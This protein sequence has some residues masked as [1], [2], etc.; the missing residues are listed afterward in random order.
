MSAL[1]GTPSF[2]CFCVFLNAR[3]FTGFS[4]NSELLATAGFGTYD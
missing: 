4:L 2:A 1:N 3:F